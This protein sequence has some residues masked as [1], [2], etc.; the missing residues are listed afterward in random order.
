ML[1]NGVTKAGFL[2][3]REAMLGCRVAPQ[4]AD[5]PPRAGFVFRQAQLYAANVRSPILFAIS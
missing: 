4:P 3:K 5:R 1:V 2:C